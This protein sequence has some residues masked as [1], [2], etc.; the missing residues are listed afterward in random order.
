MLWVTPSFVLSTERG[1][2][3]GMHSKSNQIT[4]RHVLDGTV[5]LSVIMFISAL[6]KVTMLMG[7]LAGA[8]KHVKLI[9]M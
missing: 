3:Q 2:S 9:V 6:N 1:D 7:K 5:P 8:L 4:L